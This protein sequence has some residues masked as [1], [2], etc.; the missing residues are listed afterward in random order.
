MSDTHRTEDIELSIVMPCLSEA[1]TLGACI[2]KAQRFLAEAGV[3]GEVVI[4]DNGSTDGSQRIA[5]EHGARV[6]DVERKGYGSALLAGIAAA[7]GTFVAMGD[8]DDSYDFLS[9]GPF[10]EALRGGA[11]LVMGNRFRG[12]IQ[13]GAM[14]PLHRYLGNPVLSFVGRVF[15]HSPI[16]DFHCGLRAFRRD[17]ILSLDLRTTGMEFASEMV[18]K[19][20]LRHLNIVE[21]PTT[22]APDG[23]SRRPHLRTWRDGWR[24]LR[25][26]LLYSPRWLFLIPGLVLMAAGLA[27]GAW[28]MP[29]P[30]TLGGTTLDIHTLLYAAL[31]VIVGFQSVTFAVFT[32]VFAITEG[33]L[34]A[35]E[36]LD[37][38]F[39]YVTLEVG[40]LIG[41]ILIVVGF[42]M[43]GCAF[44][45]WSHTAYGPLH[46]SQSLRVVIPA[47][48]CL[49]VGYQVVLSSFLLS[50]F[51][52]KRR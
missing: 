7:R 52:L 9:L 13:P 35:D 43:T 51:G 46:P 21:A 14:P 38:L 29:G 26:L 40:L 17:A 37:R 10:L 18:V 30:R 39:R 25:F 6:V 31:A 3:R 47:V 41:A 23:R 2:A 5:G 11:D 4:A 28:L 1:E 36:R 34:P 12:G 27:V 42:G 24:H 15:F 45:Y 8:A 44:L 49:T 20:T 48:T 32:K 22:L 33:L 50:V 16:G 19:A